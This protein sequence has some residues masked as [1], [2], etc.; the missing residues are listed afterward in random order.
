MGMQVNTVIRWADARSALWSGGFRPFFLAAGAFAAVAVPLWVLVLD[1]GLPIVGAGDPLHWHI[2]EMIFGYV[3]AVVAGFL[4]TAIPNWTGRLPVRGRPLM[5]LVLLWLVGRVAIFAAGLL[6]PVAAVI[7]AAF[8]IVLAGVAWREVISGRNLRNI[9]ICVL[10]SLFA[11]TNVAFHAEAVMA[12]AADYAIRAALGL[13]LLLISLIGGRIVPSFTRNWLAKAGATAMPAP[14]GAFDKLSLGA[15]ALAVLAW[16]AAPYEPVTA[17]LFAAAAVLQGARMLR[18]Q[19][20]AARREPLLLVLHVA[21]AWLPVAMAL[22][23]AGVVWPEIGAS[24][25]IHAFTAGG[26]GMMT[27]AVMTRATLGHTGRALTAGTGTNAIY[28][29]VF[30]G[31]AIRVAAFWLPADYVVAITLAGVLWSAGFLLFVW[32]YGPM[33]V[34]ANAR[35][36]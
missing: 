18:W 14:F 30:A 31:A 15:T 20:L 24:P 7:D 11:L 17:A 32:V 13:I 34:G 35:K 9:P 5:M 22:L 19:G 23:A 6:G 36:G 25:G 12:G 1:S 4:M 27:L 33:L 3:G 10:V 29:L 26:I 8:L 28:L 21:Y 2:H 16:T